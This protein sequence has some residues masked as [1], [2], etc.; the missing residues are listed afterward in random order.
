MSTTFEHTGEK[1]LLEV[2]SGGA[3]VE[4]VGGLAVAVLSILGLAGLASE[5]LAAITGIIFGIAMFAEGVAIATEYSGLYAR[6][7]GGLMGAVELGGGMT[8]EIMA[9]GAAI[10]LGV[11]AVVGIAPLYLLPAL[12]ITGGASLLL[13]AG[14]LQRLNSLKVSAAETPELAQRIMRVVTSS[15]AGGQMLAGVA[16]IVLGIVALA[17]LPAAASAAAAGGGAIATWLILTLVGLLVLGSSIMTS[18]GSLVGRLIQ[19]FNREAPRL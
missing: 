3:A 10:V 11:L 1:R 8:V 16:A 5:S 17:S 15:A 12:V 2:E 18:G 14:A 9:G 19:M 6:V 13:T 4:A 7:S